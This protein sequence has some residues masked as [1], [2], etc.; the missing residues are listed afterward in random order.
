M[1]FL[2]IIDIMSEKKNIKAVLRKFGF[3]RAPTL[4]AIM[5]YLGINTIA[6]IMTMDKPT[7]KKSSGYWQALSTPTIIRQL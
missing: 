2:F 5:T 7:I 1:P 3:R 6:S 4:E